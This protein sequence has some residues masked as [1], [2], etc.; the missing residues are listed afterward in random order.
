M[1]ERVKIILSFSSSQGSKI[2]FMILKLSISI[3]CYFNCVTTP[4]RLISITGPMGLTGYPWETGETGLIMGLTGYPEEAGLM[5]PTGLT[6]AI[7]L[8]KTTGLTGTKK[9]DNLKF[10]LIIL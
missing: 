4:L 7:K 2:L 1:G 8:T 6:N 5:R 9:K 3:N 10:I